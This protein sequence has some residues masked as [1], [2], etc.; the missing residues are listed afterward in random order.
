[1]SW[2]GWD[3]AVVGIFVLNLAALGWIVALA[4]KI[5]NGPVA[6][7]TGRIGGLA[8]TGKALAGAGKQEFAQNRSRIV[9]L[10][11]AVKGL[12]QAVRPGDPAQNPQLTFDYRSLMKVVSVLTTLRRGLTGLR[13]VRKAAVSSPPGPRKVAR[14]AP[15]RPFGLI[16]D[17]IRLLVD[18]RKALKR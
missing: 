4:L 3:F 11:G 7:M 2:T 5:K 9:A 14:K 16:P 6:R 12:I 1:M 8:A 10:S 18:V 13:G 17:A 15:S